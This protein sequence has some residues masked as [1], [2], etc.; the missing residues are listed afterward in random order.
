MQDEHDV[1]VLSS[2]MPY[3][4]LIE[5]DRGPDHRPNMLNNMMAIFALFL[6][7]GVNKLTVIRGIPGQSYLNTVERSISVFNLRLANCAVMMNMVLHTWLFQD[8]LTSATLLNATH[9]AINEYNNDLAA[10]IKILE[11]RAESTVAANDEA[12][13]KLSGGSDAAG[14]TALDGNDTE[15]KSLSANDSFVSG[16]MVRKFFTGFGW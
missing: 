11:Q 13:D 15:S 14:Q 6:A 16:K 8:V 7:Y 9:A 5:T 3:A 1:Q 4:I 2:Y 12:Q 10:T